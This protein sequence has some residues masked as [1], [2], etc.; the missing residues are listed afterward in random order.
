M[1]K[2]IILVH[3][4]RHSMPPIDTAF[5][6]L[7]PEAETLNLLDEALYA[8]VSAEGRIGPTVPA[9][10]RALLAYCVQSGADGIVFTGSTFGPVVDE[11]RKDIAIPVLKA[12]EAMAEVAVARGG[13]ILL[14]CTARRALPVITANLEAAATA[15]GDTLEL[16]AIAV[17]E[18]KD[19]IT[20]GDLALHDRL[21]AEAIIAAPA[22]DTILLGQISMANVRQLLPM[23]LAAKVLTSSEA[24]VQRLRQIMKPAKS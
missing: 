16:T 9:R 1:S 23:E 4:Y 11:A 20:Q 24:A 14:V 6:T 8:D 3:A 13:S 22:C 17:P 10:M 18:A 19:A 5:R 7:W 12:D 15:A 21:V 2:R